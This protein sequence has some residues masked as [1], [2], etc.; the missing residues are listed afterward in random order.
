MIIKNNIANNE[1]NNIVSIIQTYRNTKTK[2]TRK[3]GLPNLDHPDLSSLEIDAKAR[4]TE[5]D[6]VVHTK[7]SPTKKMSPT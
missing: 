5:I 2:L 3:R 1:T 6:S 4:L 7:M